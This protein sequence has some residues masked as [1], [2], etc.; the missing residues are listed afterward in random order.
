MEPSEQQRELILNMMEPYYRGCAVNVDNFD[1][2]EHF[3][4]CLRQL[5]FQSSPGYP[6]MFEKSTIG[7]WLGFD[8]T[9]FNV[10]QVEK[11]WH[12]VNQTIEGD[13]DCYWR[14]FIKQ[15]PHK[16]HKIEQSRYRLIMCPPLHVQVLWQMVFA[17]QNQKEIELSYFLPSQQGIVM[18]YGGWSHYYSQWTSNGTT[19]GT[20]AVAWDWTVPGW[21]L[22]LELAF[23]K[24]QTRGFRRDEWM[25][26]AAKLYRDA[27]R[28]CKLVFSD[29]T[30]YQQ[31]HWGIMKSG[32]VNTI[33]TNSHGGFI[34]HILYCLETSTPIEPIPRCVG[35]DKLVHEKHTEHLEVYERYGNLIKSVSENCEF[36]GHEFYSTGP[37]P[38]YLGKHVFN[39]MHAR[40]DN[41]EDMMESY[42]RL[43]ALYDDGYKFWSTVADE[44]SLGDRVLSREH[45]ISWYNNPDGA[46]Y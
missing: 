15:E 41:I 11:L 34:Y 42:L 4:T 5:E 9:S 13:V 27:F 24:R 45:Y 22:Q 1:T 16:L 23:R 35:D 39:F 36:V 7:E 30:V 14:V 8:G 28:D 37:R 17:A 33:S 12:A 29:G 26:L 40:D 3:E 19:V 46:R 21:L 2:R 44:L 43:N 25:N 38:M 6:Y 32:C 20:D 10:M 31:Q 18:P